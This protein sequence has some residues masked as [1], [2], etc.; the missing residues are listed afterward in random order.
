[1][2]K[3]AQ[4]SHNVQR[5]HKTRNRGD[6]YYCVR[7]ITVESNTLKRKIHTIQYKVV[8]NSATYDIPEKSKSMVTLMT[9]V[10]HIIY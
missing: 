1:M 8:L 10:I 3:K 5:I 7:E 9:N 4:H 2:L 6:A